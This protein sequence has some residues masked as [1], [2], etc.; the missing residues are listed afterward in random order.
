MLVEAGAQLAS[1][2]EL[3]LAAG[4]R[5]DARPSRARQLNEQRPHA[6]GGR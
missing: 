6:S 2:R 3:A 4:Q 1:D 5:D